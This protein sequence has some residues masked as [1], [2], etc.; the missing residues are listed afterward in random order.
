MPGHQNPPMSLQSEM[1]A[2]ATARLGVW[3][4]GPEYLKQLT[5]FIDKPVEQ[6]S[7]DWRVESGLLY[8]GIGDNSSPQIGDIRV[9]Y[10]LVPSPSAVSLM[11]RQAGNKI[12]PFA[13]QSGYMI[14]VIRDGRIDSST[15]IRDLQSEETALT[16]ILRALGIG[17]LW[18]GFSLIMSPL[19]SLANILPFLANVVGI[20]TVIVALALALVIGLSVIA[21]AWLLY[22]PLV[23]LG[24]IATGCVAAYG[25]IRMRP[26]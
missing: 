17:L 13:T 9:K 19:Q 1:I 12:A 15:M 2:S 16:W 21:L 6:A 25:L 18:L 20:T 8:R 11:G 26:K 4:V 24:L 7:E 3:Q 22:R 10:Q 23:G 5:G 14:N